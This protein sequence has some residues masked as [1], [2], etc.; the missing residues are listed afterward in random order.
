MKRLAIMTNADPRD[1]MNFSG[2]SYAMLT[3]LEKHFDVTW[4]NPVTP[5][6]NRIA[7]LMNYRQRKRYGKFFLNH[8]PLWLSRLESAKLSREVRKHS[9]DGVLNIG[10]G[11]PLLHYTEK[12]PVMTFADATMKQMMEHYYELQPEQ[13][14]AAKRANTREKI[15][16]DRSR[17]IL[18]T[19]QWCAD[20]VI[21][22]YDVTP[23][24]VR[25][26]KV[27]ANMDINLETKTA[28]KER[29][30]HLLFC[31]V[32]PARKGLA[33][34]ADAVAKLNQL[35]PDHDFVLDVVG[36]SEAEGITGDHVIFHGRL[37]KNKPTE[38]AKLQEFYRQSDLF[39]LP[40]RMDTIGIVF[41]EAASF[42]LPTLTCRT[43]GVPEYVVDGEMGYCLDLAADGTAFAQKALELIQNPERYE[44]FSAQAVQHI[45]EDMNWETWGKV[46][47]SYLDQMMV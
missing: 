42:G 26:V 20:S 35:D 9:I 1:R 12:A 25:M 15:T 33:I 6:S 16:F 19:S 43:G 38:E 10:M 47:S 4:I 13:A 45:R 46:V 22:D 27:G 34:A 11:V 36:L 14:K 18:T 41:L 2:T 17:M 31:G 30:I 8:V 40:T 44:R 28:P 7:Q 32:D 3:E 21:R 5:L 39:I 37:D 29:R 23:E 24:K